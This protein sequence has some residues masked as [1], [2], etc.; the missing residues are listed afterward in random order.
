MNLLNDVKDQDWVPLAEETLVTPPP[1]LD[2]DKKEALVED[3]PNQPKLSEN[4]IQDWQYTKKKSSFARPFFILLAVIALLLGG[5]YIYNN[6]FVN[7]GQKSQITDSNQTKVSDQPQTENMTPVETAVPETADD[8]PAASSDVS[9]INRTAQQMQAVVNSISPAV[10]LSTL[11]MD[12][13]SLS[14]EVTSNSKNNIDDFYASLQQKFSDKLSQS[15]PT[16]SSGKYKVLISGTLS[17]NGSQ[18]AILS[19]AISQQKLQSDLRAVASRSGVT[20]QDVTMGRQFTVGNLKKT[21]IFI[22]VS[23]PIE[24]CQSFFTLVSE[25]NEALRVSKSY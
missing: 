4:D 8:Q 19:G 9:G 7:G 3:K 21:P 13:S 18:T 12:E 22:K 20:L 5:Y 14:A 2:Q 11:I 17:K 1:I 16:G 25:N 15:K 24:K 10:K 23:G 6:Y